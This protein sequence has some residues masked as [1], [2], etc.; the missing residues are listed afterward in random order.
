MARDRRNG[1]R[2]CQRTP[3]WELIKGILDRVQAEPRRARRLKLL[4]VACLETL[5]SVPD[6]LRAALDRCLDDLIPPRDTAA[7]RSLA[8]AGEPVLARLPDSLEGLSGTVAAAAIQTAWLIN[9]P[10]AL[11]VLARYATDPRFDFELGVA[12][13]YFDPDEYA[14]RVLAARPPG[15]SLYVEHSR[16]QLAALD[17]AS[18]LSELEIH[19]TGPVDLSFLTAHAASLRHLALYC[20]EP[21]ADLTA[22]PELPEI[23]GLAVGLPGLANLGFLDALPPLKTVWLTHCQDI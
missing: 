20:E 16:A 4:T 8:T 17:K 22:L 1:R 21:G 13:D 12:W 23:E 6:D 2:P 15:G 18:P 3:T 10:E 5:P 19:Q 11:D 7:A 9:G 14:E